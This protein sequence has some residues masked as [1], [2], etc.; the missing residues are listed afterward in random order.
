MDPLTALSVAGTIIQFVDFGSK[1]F[2][3]SVQLYKSSQGSLKANEELELVTGDLQCVVTKLRGSFSTVPTE[4]VSSFSIT[5]DE[6]RRNFL[7]ICDEATEIAHELLLRLN[8]LKAEDG[9]NR[10]WKSLKA[11]VK[12]AW[13]KDEIKS[14]RQ[15]LSLLKES[16]SSGSMLLLGEKID[17]ASLRSS[18][19][20][21]SLDTQTQQMLES[22]M[23]ME[24]G[25]SKE[26]VEFTTKLICRSEAVNQDEHQ[27]TRQL[28]TDLRNSFTSRDSPADII[29]A[30]IEMLSVG[31]EEEQYL[32]HTIQS[33]ILGLLRYPY[34]TGR[35]E[36]LLQAHPQTFDWIFADADDWEFPWTDFGKWLREGQGIY[37]INGKA[38]SGKSTLMKHVYDDQR[39]QDHLRQWSKNPISGLIPYCTATFFFW[40]TGTTLQKSQEGLLRSLLFQI[41]GDHPDL[42][43]LVFPTRWA[44]LYNGTLSIGRKI[45]P[46]PWSLTQL[47]KALERLTGQT[48]YPLNVL[49]YIDGLD[50][51]SG[52]AEKLCTFFKHLST[53]SVSAKFCLSS[54]PWVMFKQTFQGCASLRLQD[55]TAKDIKTYVNDKLSESSAFE[56]LAARENE[57]ASKLAQAILDRADGVF[58]WV[59]IVVRLLVRGASNRDTVPQLWT[60]SKSFPTELYDLFESILSRIEPCY[61]DWASKAFQFMIASAQLASDPFRRSMSGPIPTTTSDESNMGRGVSPLTLIEFTFALDENNEWEGMTVLS[62]PQLVS[63]LEET[64]IHLTARCAGLLEV[65]DS[66]NLT[67]FGSSF[68]RI[69]WMHRTAR[70]FVCQ[71]TIWTKT[72]AGD[73]F[74]DPSAC[75]GLMKSAIVSLSILECEKAWF[76]RKDNPPNSSTMKPL[77]F[78]ALIYA[79]HADGDSP[80]RKLRT[81]LLT[82]LLNTDVPFDHPPSLPRGKTPLDRA[83]LYC[84]AD[85]VEDLLTGSEPSTRRRTV[86]ALFVPLCTPGRYWSQDY[87]FPTSRMLDC[88]LTM[89][90]LPPRDTSDLRATI[91]PSQYPGV[92]GDLYGELLNSN[93]FTIPPIKIPRFV[94]S[95]LSIIGGL[96]KARVDPT[97][98]LAYIPKNF[99][100]NKEAIQSNVEKDVAVLLESERV[101]IV[102]VLIKIKQAITDEIDLTKKRKRGFVLKRQVIQISDDS[103]PDDTVFIEERPCYR[104]KRIKTNDDG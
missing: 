85:F 11:A 38:A 101:N 88:L 97:G 74:G 6:H 60:R 100:L 26:I 65:S 37:W 64:Q 53:K 27:K 98:T 80:T 91:S 22:V 70:D 82:K 19:R 29:T 86:E 20:F 41:L 73:C 42:I 5:D 50:E 68:R 92:Y 59:E 76:L 9:N 33:E 2:D 55:L 28:I 77:A 69:L 17:A 83:T 1:L 16:L 67:G 87:P 32:R 52:D 35:Y 25:L 95:Q 58:L 15:R 71:S 47:Q 93:S 78:N 89:G 99:V 57:L 79:Y 54:R 13:S 12:A 7:T 104:N 14:L 46:E 10:A 24:K 30:Q 102:T 31:H 62:K 21:D 63:K 96:L 61:L 90:N 39:T 44:E 18:A 94:E 23:N 3:H 48:Q 34:M 4:N 66:G 84:L 36:Q 72:M 43:H 45:H 81:K 75:V 8:G 40:S 51:F 49:F 103:E 56:Q